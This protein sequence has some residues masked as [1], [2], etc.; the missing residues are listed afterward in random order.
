MVIFSGSGNR[1]YALDEISGVELW[2]TGFTITGGMSYGNPAYYAG[3]IFVTTQSGLVYCVNATNGAKLWENQ[4]TSTGY[5]Q[6]SPTVA[7]DKVY[8]TTTDSYI[9]G[10]NVSNGQYGNWFFT[11]QGAIYST[12]AVS[13]NMVYFGCDDHRVYALDTSNPLGFIQAWRFMTNG[14]VRSSPCVA[15]GKVFIGTDYNDHSVLAL[16]ATATNPNGQLVWKYI[17]NAAA[18]PFVGSA[19]FCNSRV[20][21]GGYSGKVYCLNANASPGRYTEDQP[22]CKIWSQT[23]GGYNVYSYS[24]AIAGDRLFA[25]DGSRVVYALD[26]TSGG[27]FTTWF[28]R[29]PTATALN[30]PVI[31]DGRVFVVDYYGI[32]CIGDYY[33]PVTYYYTVTP[34]GAGGQS[35]VIRLDVANATPSKTI[36]VQLLVSQKKINY[37]ATGIDGTLGMSEITMPNLMLGGP[38]FVRV[39]GAIITSA[40]TTPINATHSSIHFNYDQ[41]V[42]GIEITGTTTVPEFP[43]TLILPLLMTMSLIAVAFAKKKLPKN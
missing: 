2:R 36:N 8:V 4:V 38:Y 20:Y 42:N 29:N 30:E 3:R 6:S 9:F 18:A 27:A 11:A 28:F 1:I 22:G 32:Y 21:F 15:D 16:N 26:I 14:T 13:G 5:I 23:I 25:S 37:T 31:A 41:S 12:P 24:V 7:N 35:F 40:I 33:P 43:S 10:C 19:A 39:N 34:P 17:L